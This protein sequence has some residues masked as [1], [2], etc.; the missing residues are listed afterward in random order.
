LAL[1]PGGS[2]VQTYIRE[3]LNELP[4][5]L[6]AADLSAVV[7]RDAVGE[8]PSAIKPASRPVASGAVRAAFGAVPDVSCELFHGLDVDIPLFSRGATAATVHDLAVLDMPSASSRVRVAGESRLIHHALRRADLLLA[9]SRFTADRIAAVSGRQATV[10]ELAPASWTRPA[11]AEE[12]AAVRRKY[13]LPD[14]FM[15]QVGTVEPRKDLQLVADVAEQLGVRCVLAGAGST[16]AEAPR[17]TLGLGYVD[18]D[19]LPGLYG[20]ATVTAYASRYEGFGLPPVEAMACGGAVVASAVGALPDVVGDG[21][22]LV[23]SHRISDWVTALQPLVFDAAARSELVAKG[24]RVAAGLT[25]A[26]TAE[27]T[28]RAYRDVGLSW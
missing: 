7:Q 11:D 1:R 13:E 20:A 8:L 23:D 4:K 17:G 3:L 21:A 27:Q 6:A 25:W 16:S 18:V 22:V 15:L 5:H 26:R 19:D 9:V 12:I 2:G 10:V 28:V 24:L 14:R